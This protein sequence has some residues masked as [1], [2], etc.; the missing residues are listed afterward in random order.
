[1]RVE[2]SQELV[3]AGYTPGAHGV[4]A[5]LTSFYKVRTDLLFVPIQFRAAIRAARNYHPKQTTYP[6]S[7]TGVWLD[8]GLLRGVFREIIAGSC[9]AVKREELWRETL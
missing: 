2:L 1:M 9:S 5:V 4:D 3:I 7:G 6:C 8:H